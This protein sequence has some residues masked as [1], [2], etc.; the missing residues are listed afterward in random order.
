VPFDVAMSL[1]DVDAK[2]YFIVFG[3]IDG[4]EFDFNAMKWVEKK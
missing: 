1:E 3:E 4:G 2:A